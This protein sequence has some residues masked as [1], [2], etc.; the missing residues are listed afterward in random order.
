MVVLLHAAGGALGV[1][2]NFIWPRFLTAF[3]E[4]GLADVC[5][6]V[7]TDFVEMGNG[8][9]DLRG[10]VTLVVL[11]VRPAPCRKERHCDGHQ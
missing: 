1:R 5:A 4:D 3:S 11:V 10:H 8:R 6:L 2:F 7:E 9:L